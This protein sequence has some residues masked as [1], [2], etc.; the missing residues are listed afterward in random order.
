MA[1][2]D[3]NGVR[4]HYQQDGDAALP[5]LLLSNSL[6]SSI[7]LWDAQMPSL[8]EHF[9]VLRYDTRGHGQSSVPPGPYSLDQLGSDVV[10]LLAHLGIARTH[11]LGISMGGLTGQWLAL[12]HPELVDRLVLANTAAEFGSPEMWTTRIEKVLSEGVGALL[13]GV[14]SRWLTADYSKANPV[15]TARIRAMVKATDDE[16]YAA[17]CAAVRESDLRGQVAGIDAPT[18]VIGGTFDLSSPPASSRFLADNIP[19]ARYLELATAHL[20]NVEQPDAFNAA[21]VGFLTGK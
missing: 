3:L 2:A 9:H 8:T 13:D 17:C 10:A 4:L 18:L 1:F 11:F 16:G 5:P 20:S 15:V 19:G 12:H 14:M 6:G 7:D 21:A